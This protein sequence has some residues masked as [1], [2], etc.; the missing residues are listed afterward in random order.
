MKRTKKNYCTITILAK[1]NVLKKRKSEALLVDVKTLDE[2]LELSE[3]KKRK[4]R[5]ISPLT[6][7]S[8]LYHS[9]FL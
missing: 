3:A 4:N 6:L 8:S 9:F 5:Q 2:T 7:M 1:G